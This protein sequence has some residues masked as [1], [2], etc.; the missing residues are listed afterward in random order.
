MR[1]YLFEAMVSLLISDSQTDVMWD[2]WNHKYET[3]EFMQGAFLP[4]DHYIFIKTG[5][6]TIHHQMKGGSVCRAMKEVASPT[7]YFNN[8]TLNK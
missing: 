2:I 1:V 5:P 8:K 4:P 7:A 6:F 3:R